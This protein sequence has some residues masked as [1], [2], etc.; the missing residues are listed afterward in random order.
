MGVVCDG[1]F[2]GVGDCLCVGGS[3]EG[4]DGAE[5]GMERTGE[6]ERI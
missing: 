2:G 6:E 4:E 3:M 5:E 1:A